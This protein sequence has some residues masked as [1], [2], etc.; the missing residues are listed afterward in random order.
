MGQIQ[1]P[2]RWCPCC[3]AITGVR[4]G[5]ERTTQGSLD[6]VTSRSP[7]W[8][9][10]DCTATPRQ[11]CKSERGER[12]WGD[13]LALGF[14]GQIR[15]PRRWCPCRAVIT[16]VRRGRECTT[17]GSLDTVTCCVPQWEARYRTG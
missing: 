13:P 6:T 3:A 2:R 7:Q 16:G 1:I 11:W 12:H 14:V 9:T 8:E 4:R 17:Q 15:I 5:C 10:R